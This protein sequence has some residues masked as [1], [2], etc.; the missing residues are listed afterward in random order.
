MKCRNEGDWEMSC[1]L[2]DSSHPLRVRLP[3]LKFGNKIK[4]AR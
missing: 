3:V 4:N 2:R 1:A